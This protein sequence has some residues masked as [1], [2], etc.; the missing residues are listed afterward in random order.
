MA[1][2]TFARVLL[3][4]SIDVWTNTYN[5]RSAQGDVFSSNCRQVGSTISGARRHTA[6]SAP[7]DSGRST[8]A[9]DRLQPV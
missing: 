8:C 7:A 2:W 9:R 6:T 5:T 1:T 3:G 4:V